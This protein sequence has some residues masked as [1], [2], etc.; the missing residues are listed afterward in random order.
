[1]H[2]AHTREM[3]DLHKT[4]IIELKLSSILFELKIYHVASNRIQISEQTHTKL[5]CFIDGVF[6]LR[7]SIIAITG[8][9][10][11]SDR[12]QL[13]IKFKMF[14]MEIGTAAKV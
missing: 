2:F 11:A 3:C 10:L 1:M 6:R 12:Q 14:E 5:I 13:K 9:N 7:P 4:N 8:C